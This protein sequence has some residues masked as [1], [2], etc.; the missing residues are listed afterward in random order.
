[1]LHDIVGDVNQAVDVL[2]DLDERAELGEV[3]HLALDLRADGIL[4][5]QL[6]PR[7]ALDLLETERD[8]ARRGSTPS[9]IASTES[10]TLRIFDGCLTRL[11][12]DISLTWMSLRPRLELDERAVVG[13]AH[14]LAAHARAD[15]IA[16][17]TVGPRILHEL[18]V[19]ER[20]ALGRG[21]VLQHDHVDFVVD[22]EDLGRWPTRPHDM[23][24]D[25]QQT[26]D[27]HR[28]R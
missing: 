24:G 18:L 4:L 13:Q 19:S 14:D 7:V 11:L 6:V 1:L 17:L 23:S 2:L 16:V 26:V 22:L 5:A 25:V 8:A 9:T 21:V 12:H 10:P 3:A 15:G 28:G 27:A 20:D